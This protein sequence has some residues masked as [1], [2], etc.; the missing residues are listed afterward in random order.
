MYLYSCKSSSVLSFKVFN[1]YI[2]TDLNVLGGL[3]EAPNEVKNTG[4]SW[5]I[6]QKKFGWVPAGI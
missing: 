3:K 2:F 1:V 6:N 5:Q 4:I